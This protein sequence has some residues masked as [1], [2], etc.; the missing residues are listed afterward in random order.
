[1]YGLLGPATRAHLAAAAQ[2]AGE[3]AGGD[4]RFS[5]AEMLGAAGG[6]QP[7][8]RGF[9]VVTHHRDRVLVGA[10]TPD[11]TSVQYTLVRVSGH[12]RVELVPEAPAGDS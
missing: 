10:T 3:V 9:R 6:E 5:P 1:M 4:R 12:W 11:G 7:T 2:R 8:A